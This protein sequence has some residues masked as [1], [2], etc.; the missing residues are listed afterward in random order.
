MDICF[1]LSDDI[2]FD[3]FGKSVASLEDDLDVLGLGV[4]LPGGPVFLR[5]SAKSAVGDRRGCHLG[6]SKFF[7]SVSYRVL[8][9]RILRLNKPPYLSRSWVSG[10]NG[11][12]P[13]S[14]SIHPTPIYHHILS[15]G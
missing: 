13:R 7:S 8:Q 12:S 2:D 15:H 6:E 4:S 11:L 14:G 10:Y 1:A 9:K 5:K 3:T